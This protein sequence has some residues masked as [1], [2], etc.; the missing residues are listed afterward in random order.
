M[1]ENSFGMWHPTVVPS[2]FDDR[3]ENEDDAETE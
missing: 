1:P 2:N 3:T